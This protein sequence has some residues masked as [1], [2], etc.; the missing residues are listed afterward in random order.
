MQKYFYSQFLH[1]FWWKLKSCFDF[2]FFHNSNLQ[3][4]TADK[5]N[6]YVDFSNSD[7]FDVFDNLGFQR[8]IFNDDNGCVDLPNFDKIDHLVFQ[9]L[10]I[11]IQIFCRQNKSRRFF[12]GV[13]YFRHIIKN[14]KLMQLDA[15]RAHNLL[16][17]WRA[18]AMQHAMIEKIEFWLFLHTRI[19]S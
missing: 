6:D 14:K 19:S 12:S 7:N 9:Q 13:N 17:I 16:K 8:L 2:K 10:Q 5:N 4:L 15:G 1:F 11:L 18:I 3:R